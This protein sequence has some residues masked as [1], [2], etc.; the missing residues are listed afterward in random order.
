MPL[1]H[2]EVWKAAR[3]ELLAGG[4]GACAHDLLE[5]CDFDGATAGVNFER[6]FVGGAG[7]FAGLLEDAGNTKVDDAI[8]FA[9]HAGVCRWNEIGSERGRALRIDEAFHVLHEIF[10]AFR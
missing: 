3:S 9:Q 8:L 6:G 5:A 2:P 7:S 4:G 1:E 10:P